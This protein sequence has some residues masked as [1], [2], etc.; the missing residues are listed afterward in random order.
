MGTLIASGLRRRES[1]PGVSMQP[2]WIAYWVDPKT[3]WLSRIA[4]L[5]TSPSGVF[6]TW[7]TSPSWRDVCE[8]TSKKETS[9]LVDDG[10]AVVTYSATDRIGG[11][12][13]AAFRRRI[14]WDETW[15]HAKPNP[16]QNVSRKP[17][18]KVGS[19]IWHVHLSSTTRTA[20]VTVVG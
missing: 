20:I 15:E 17:N 12:W 16:I 9:V 6:F 2:Y 5:W 4:T 11:L 10:W 13:E 7:E 1:T 8:R 3:L 18:S 19:W 14:S